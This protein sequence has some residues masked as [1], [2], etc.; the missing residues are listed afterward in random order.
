[1]TLIELLFFVILVSIGIGVGSLVAKFLGI[2][3]GI[4]AGILA[5]AGFIYLTKILS[6]AGHRRHCR[7]M[8]EKYTRIF[9]VRDLP[10]DETSIILPKNSEIKTGDYGWESGP[11]RKNGLIY[12]RGFDEKWKFIWWAGFQPEQIEFV[13]PKPFSDY[14][15]HLPDR[16]DL[17][18]NPC[19][20]PVQLR[21]GTN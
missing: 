12:L 20:F 2:F 1:M 14:D 8:A 10:T 21:S 13:C 16:K 6:V 9:R 7:K 15:R 3:A 5:V 11:I 17:L 18:K 4:G 19:P